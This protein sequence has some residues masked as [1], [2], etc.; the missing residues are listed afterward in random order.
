MQRPAA[1]P[2]VHAQSPK[3]P[4]LAGADNLYI[5]NAGLVLLANY[6]QRLFDMLKLRDGPQLR[7]AASQSRA[8]RC[9][10]YLVDGHEDGCEPEWVLPKL[11]CGMPLMQPLTDEP[12]LDDDTRALLDSLLQAVIAH[13]TA[14]GRTSVAGLQATFLRREGRL[15]REAA[16]AGTHWR[17]AVRPGPFDMLLDRLPWSYATIKLPWMTE[18]LY[19]DWR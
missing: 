6:T 19:V 16:Q 17:L 11:L 18:V 9:L 7:D 8:V 3:S 14:V 13:W 10:A 2:S 12:G 4:D 1:S 5:A 15:Q